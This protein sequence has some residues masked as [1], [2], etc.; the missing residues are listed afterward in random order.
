MKLQEKSTGIFV[1]QDVLD[2]KNFIQ[3]LEKECL[4]GAETFWEKSLTGPNGEANEYRTSDS[5]DLQWI[6]NPNKTHPLYDMFRKDIY[7]PL[8]DC[9]LDYSSYFM[10]KSGY[11]EP[12]QMLKYENGARYGTHLDAGARFRRLFSLVAILE[13]TSSGGVL[14]FPFHKVE[15]EPVAG[16]VVLFPSGLTYDHQAH[17]VKDG[18]KYSL[19]TWFA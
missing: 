1:Y 6:M 2:G 5:C 12:M 18:I 7:L 17:P 8:Q 4:R 10:A 15:I 3:E 16:S 19:V 14:E 9:F 13:N 11:H